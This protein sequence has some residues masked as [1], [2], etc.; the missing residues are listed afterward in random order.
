[1][2]NVPQKGDTIKNTPTL[3]F[4]TYVASDFKTC[5]VEIFVKLE[6][7]LLL[8]K[9][10]SPIHPYDGNCHIFSINYQRLFH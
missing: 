5:K 2:I 4:I 1:M 8:S 10:V 3:K 9:I 6:F 7:K